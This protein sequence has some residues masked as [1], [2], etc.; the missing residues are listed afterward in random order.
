[1]R[2]PL[3]AGSVHS[4]RFVVEALAG[5]GGS[6][7]VYRAVDRESGRLV[8]LKVSHDIE[9]YGA[10]RFVREAELLEAL[11]HR[12]I[13]EHV[14]HGVT[15]GVPYLAMEWLE[16]ED[17]EQRLERGPLAIEEVLELAGNVA[18]AL[19]AAHDR[20]VVHRDV[21]PSN[22]FLGH[23]KIENTKILDFGIARVDGGAQFTR[24]GEALGTPAYM[25]P[26][27]A[28]GARDLDARTD[29]FALGCVLY[30]CLAGRPPF[31][32]DH[33]LAVMAKILIEEPPPIETLR[34]DVPDALASLVDA[35]LSKER[36]ARP[37]DGRAVSEAVRTIR[38]SLQPKPVSEP[39]PPPPPPPPRAV[40]TNREQKLLSVLFVARVADTLLSEREAYQ[41]TMFVESES[42]GGTIDTVYSEVLKHGGGAARLVDGSI[43]VTLPGQG[44]V[45]EQ[46]A[47]A[48]RCALSVSHAL[49]QHPIAL[50]TGRADV[51]GGFPVGRV[52]DRGVR[53]L[54]SRVAQPSG[55]EGITID[56]V[57]AGL[58]DRR[59]EISAHEA[60]FQLVSE[61]ETGDAPPTFMGK[62]QP[63]VGRDDELGRML[64]HYEACATEERAQ[65]ML[66][67]GAPGAGKSRLG[68]ELCAS[69]SARHP[70]PLTLVGRGSSHLTDLPMGVIAGA[71]AQL[72]GLHEQE[73]L[74]VA[75][76]RVRARVGRN[77]PR[78]ERD[79][80][81]GFLGEL[82]GVRF[83]DETHPTLV[84]AR[85]DSVK[86]GDLIRA[87]WE[88]LLTAELA[89]GPVLLLIDDIHLADA[90]S[91]SLI[92]GA[93]R[94][95][96]EAPLF[97][98]GLAR[99]EV[100]AAFPGLWSTRSLTRFELARLSR[101]AAIQICQHVMGDGVP[102]LELERLVAQADGN[103]FYLEELLRTVA[104]GR[105]GRLPETLLA[106]VQAR[107]DAQGPDARR[108]LRACSV[109]G[110]NCSL[111]GAKFLV[112]EADAA[113]AIAT[114]VKLCDAEL[115][116]SSG[117]GVTTGDTRVSFP[118]AVIREAAYAT[119]TEEDRKLGHRL[120]AEWLEKSSSGRDAAVIADHFEQAGELHRAAAYFAR[121]A[122]IAI[123]A[124]DFA[125]AVARA[126]RG[127]QAGVAGP[128][129][130]RIRLLQS[131]AHRQL[132]NNA[133]M[134]ARA[135]E[136]LALLPHR[137]P[138][139]WAAL[140]NGVQASL[141][142]GELASVAEISN[143][144]GPPPFGELP[145]GATRA[146]HY[147]HVGGLGALAEAILS[148]AM[149]NIGDFT[150]DPAKWGWAYR[151]YST[152][153]VFAGD[154]GTA[155]E[156][157][158]LAIRAFEAGG[159]LR[160]AASEGVN[161]GLMRL[162]LGLNDEARKTLRDC[163]ARFERLALRHLTAHACI[164]LA[165]AETRLGYLTSAL[166][167]A[168][169]AIVFFNEQGDKR[170]GG[171]S[172]TTLA[173]LHLAQGRFEVA[174]DVTR[175]ASELLE[176]IP[177]LRPANAATRAQVLLALGRND[178]ALSVATEGFRP[179]ADGVKLDDGEALTR[180]A[181]AE[182]L[183]AN[184]QRE[185]AA[186][187]I[188]GARARLRARAGA[189]R[190]SAWQKGFLES[191][192]EN[193]KTLEL[194]AEL[195]PEDAPTRR[196]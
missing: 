78:A 79:R 15:D 34:P 74:D 3:A 154:T 195:A 102:E 119:L 143:M 111:G 63:F 187:V 161:L 171:F 90:A 123:E 14:A 168:Q 72:F 173:R 144:I 30:E 116:V 43:V 62:T 27:Q 99:R 182:A 70:T 180:L 112:G 170:M 152:R 106:M 88:E 80:I 76:H 141:R 153:A 117:A 159:D 42:T 8:A 166:G 139:W 169:R 132:G 38:A 172:H 21:K 129:L 194:A 148:Q 29:V 186:R 113:D 131:E 156:Q 41:P 122:E 163:L 83:P 37:A 97:V 12:G 6:S 10:D 140:A 174:L 58:L 85:L 2:G 47:R 138:P 36:T 52:I 91:V 100:D 177:T 178:E 120:A 107:L 92:D 155:A 150:R 98:V 84:A 110:D 96:A 9:Q 147:L 137:S 125:G 69:L 103:P 115:L 55:N 32:A 86:M 142:M 87:A 118:S 45:L 192:P 65:A 66:V 104:E 185:D 175:V 61:R 11:S 19:S 135:K 48:A 95:F 93:L 25:A 54:A 196:L 193:R 49:P 68:H 82:L 136:A 33:P 13:V 67:V 127:A 53:L 149:S 51:T 176:N 77:V 101:T 4:G 124:H 167:L 130:G 35:M 157:L 184:G 81:A 44:P 23:Q 114:I 108:L 183:L 188:G 39:P 121:A 189:I 105:G 1:V 50:V 160:E 17:L 145:S 40:L 24:F 191:V 134:Q 26:E 128:L 28:K 20:G 151:A 18:A 179:L 165:V 22:V 133:P 71:L 89:A 181:Y 164:G 5:E 59:F 158:E 16:G 31:W 57:T 162:E 56:D 75:R 94:V 60:G 190:N 7:E 73:G 109:F 126:D 146:A 46:A 64:A